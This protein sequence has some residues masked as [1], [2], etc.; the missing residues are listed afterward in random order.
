MKAQL[1]FLSGARAG[2]V[3]VFRKAYIGLGRHPL[4]APA[5]HDLLEY[6]WDGRVHLKYYVARLLDMCV[7]R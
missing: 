5:P 3:E 2:Q 4:R 1:R 7:S 6:F